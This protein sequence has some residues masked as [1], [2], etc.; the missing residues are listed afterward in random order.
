MKSSLANPLQCVTLSEMLNR[1]HPVPFSSL[2]TFEELSL[3]TQFLGAKSNRLPFVV[4]KNSGNTTML[5]L[6]ILQEATEMLVPSD[7]TN[8]VSSVIFVEPRTAL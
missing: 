5:L 7:V 8:D 1:R 6:P 2:C 3:F 4:V